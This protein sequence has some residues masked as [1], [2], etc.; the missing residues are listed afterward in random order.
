MLLLINDRLGVNTICSC[1]NLSSS[2]ALPV[3]KYGKLLGELLEEVVFEARFR[4]G[5]LRGEERSP[6]YLTN[7]TSYQDK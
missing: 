1:T 4:C 2:L 3:I 7:L 6:I 5:H